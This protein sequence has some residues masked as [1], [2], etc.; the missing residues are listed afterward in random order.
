MNF[1]IS[2]HP[3]KISVIEELK[4]RSGWLILRRLV[5]DSFDREEYLLFSGFDDNGRLL[6][7]ETCEKL[8]NCQGT[9]SICDEMPSP[10]KDRLNIEA[11]RHG[12]ATISRSLEENNRHFSEARER[13]EKWA[14]DMVLAAEKE[15]KDTKERIK[16][17]TRQARLATT[18]EEQHKIQEQIRDL[19]KKKRRQRQSIFDIEDEI[20]GKRDA[21]IE[22]LERRMAQKTTT[23]E[24]FTI[25]WTVA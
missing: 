1:D 22:A 11:E 20:V 8:F 10:V 2:H 6:D 4:G 13:L 17:L 14:D 5:I 21:L 9:V 25:R 24:L 3:A 18:T 19:E 15:L 12:K 7:Q 23:E 16:A